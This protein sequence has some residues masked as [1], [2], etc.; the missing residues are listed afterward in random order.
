MQEC[1]KTALR[2]VR[3]AREARF[4]SS[5][6]SKGLERSIR[7]NRGL[8]SGEFQFL[9]ANRRTRSTFFS[10]ER[11]NGKSWNIPLPKQSF[12]RSF[13][14]SNTTSGREKDSAN[15]AF[16]VQIRPALVPDQMNL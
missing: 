11:P 12:L 5:A 7:V 13:T 9:G 1:G 4:A 8:A 2:L 15:G 10:T 6:D 3:A 16:G 14:I